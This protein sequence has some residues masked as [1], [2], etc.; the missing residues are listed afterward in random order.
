MMVMVHRRLILTTSGGNDSYKHFQIPARAPNEQPYAHSR[1]RNPHLHHRNPPK[2]A[3]VPLFC[4]LF[5]YAID[6]CLRMHCS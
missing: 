4:A 3:F 6:E 2:C 5:T 1:H